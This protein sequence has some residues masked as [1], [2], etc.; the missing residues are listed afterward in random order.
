MTKQDYIQ[1]IREY[2]GIANCELFFTWLKENPNFIDCH[3]IEI[4]IN[5]MMYTVAALSFMKG[6]TL[7]DLHGFK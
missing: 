3:E 6:V 1:C 5:F 4:E 7:G 2:Q